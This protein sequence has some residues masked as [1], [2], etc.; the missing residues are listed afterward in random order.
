MPDGCSTG[1]VRESPPTRRGLLF[2]CLAAGLLITFLIYWPTLDLPFY[3]DDFVYV[4][5]SPAVGFWGYLTRA[6]PDLGFY[7]PVDWFVLESCQSMV[8]LQTWP[9][10]L[11][12]IGLHFLLVP[13]YP[14]IIAFLAFGCQ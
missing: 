4:R 11:A 8:G 14:G 5:T 2:L 7:R 1:S 12:S 6:H 9:I 13:I 3:M 10:H